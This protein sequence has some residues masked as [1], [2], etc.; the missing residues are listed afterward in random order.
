[1]RKVKS[2]LAFQSIST[3]INVDCI[4][5]TFGLTGDDIFGFSLF[6]AG[7]GAQHIDVHN[8]L[9][10]IEL[11]EVINQLEQLGPNSP[12]IV[13]TFKVGMFSRVK[14][15]FRSYDKASGYKVKGS[16]SS[17]LLYSVSGFNSSNCSESDI[18]RL[19]LN[20][21]KCHDSMSSV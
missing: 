1:M 18:N 11:S 7:S 2:D 8:P 20:L 17:F 3:R 10:A 12:K 13:I 15:S 9:K 6:C 5:F 21:R 19:I 16:I 14:L 4:T